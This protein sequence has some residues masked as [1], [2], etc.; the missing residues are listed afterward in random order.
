MP[1]A[2]SNCRLTFSGWPVRKIQ[3]SNITNRYLSS[4]AKRLRESGRV[5]R[6]AIGNLMQGVHLAVSNDPPSAPPRGKSHRGPRRTPSNHGIPRSLAPRCSSDRS[7]TVPCPTHAMKSWFMCGSLEPVAGQLSEDDLHSCSALR[8]DGE[9]RATM[10]TRFIEKTHPAVTDAK[11]DVIFSELPY[12]GPGAVLVNRSR[13]VGG[14]PEFLHQ[15]VHR[16]PGP[17]RH[18]SS[19]SSLVNTI[20]SPEKARSSYQR[21]NPTPAP[22]PADVR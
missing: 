13:S 7:K 4:W 9:R 16:V 21:A 8:R 3:A 2:V 5:K 19:F 12:P 18:N 10:R 15:R 22:V 6:S 17:T 14:E 20:A 11:R 1:I